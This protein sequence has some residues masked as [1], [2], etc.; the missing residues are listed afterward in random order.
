MPFLHLRLAGLALTDLRRQTL[1]R[2][3]TD[4]TAQHLGKRH[5][6]T[7]VLIEEIAVAGW[8]VGAAP[9][10]VAAHLEIAVTEGTNTQAQKAAFLEAVGMLMREVAGPALPVASYGMIHE[11]PAESWGYDGQTQAARRVA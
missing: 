2:R 11:I 7:A 5:D 10:P 8:A 1:Q 9:V 4:L 3:L 6:L